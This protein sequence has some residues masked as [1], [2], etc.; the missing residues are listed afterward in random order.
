MNGEA[1]PKPCQQ[2]ES[3]RF[4]KT[5]RAVPE[6]RRAPPV[7]PP[8]RPEGARDSSRALAMAREGR[9]LDVAAERAR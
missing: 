7:A 8:S 1:P 5:S 4:P 2:P 3:R 6:P 9:G